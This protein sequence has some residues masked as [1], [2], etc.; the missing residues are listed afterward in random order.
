MVRWG[1]SKSG[2][3]GSTVRGKGGSRLG[4]GG[5][6]EKGCNGRSC[7]VHS[8]NGRGRPGRQGGLAHAGLMVQLLAHANQGAAYEHS[9]H[10]TPM[11]GV[12]TGQLGCAGHNAA[13]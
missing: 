2:K 1:R 3:K 7:D 13:W 8:R 9:W 11:Q 6:D 10:R 5:T 12:L 4:V